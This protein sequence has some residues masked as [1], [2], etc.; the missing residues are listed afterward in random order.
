M[1]AFVFAYDR[2]DSMT[3]A[4]MLEEGNVQ[5]VVLCHSE[6]AKQKFIEHGTA[7]EQN[8]VNTNQP[9]GLAWNRNV[10]LE[11]M[12]KDEWALFLVDDLKS[13]TKI[14]NYHDRTDN[15]LGIHMDNQDKFPKSYMKQPLSMEDFLHYCDELATVCE[16]LGSRLGG[17]CGIDNPPFRNSK[18]KFNTL[19]DGR[20]WIVQKG[21]LRFDTNA[22]LIDDTCWTV[23]NI[24]H[25][26]T[27]VVN[28]WLLPDCKRYSAGAF[29]SIEE[30]LPQKIQ[31]AN[32]LTKAYPSLIKFAKKAGWPDDAH[33]RIRQSLSRETIQNFTDQATHISNKWRETNPIPHKPN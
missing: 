31:E 15:T 11:M 10:A 12:E 20:A 25:Y 29:G 4:K 2:F 8:I 27:V 33:V 1:R 17:F 18:W 3:T 28:Q 24:L 30:R 14:D 21:K 9:K 7:L 26:G 16:A 13:L 23:Q 19:A 22:Q 6:E 5:H 32:Y